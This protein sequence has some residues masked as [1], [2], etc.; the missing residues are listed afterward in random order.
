[1]IERIRKKLII[2]YTT[3]IALILF[4]CFGGSYIA[5]RHS[6]IRFMQDSLHDYLTEE[7]WEAST[8]LRQ[9]K[10][11]PEIH[12]I[13]SDINSSHNFTYW[14][15]NKKL[16]LAEEPLD[17][18]IAAELLQRLTQRDFAAG[19]IYYENIKHNKQKWYFW[20]LKQNLQLEGGKTAEIFVLSNYTPIRKSTKA[21]IK[22][23]V[24]AAVAWIIIAYLV[25]SLLVSRS[26]KYIDMM[27]QKQKQFVSDAS[28]ELRT[29][30]S[31]LLA[32]TELLE[33][34]QQK[35]ETTANMKE[36]IL[37]INKLIDSLLE[38]ARYDS[39]KMPLHKNVFNLENMVAEVV[40]SISLL[41]PEGAIRLIKPRQK[42]NIV[43][44][45]EMLRRLMYILL[46]NAVK[47]TPEQ[48]EIIIR[49]KRDGNETV[50]TVSDNG[51]GIAAGDI[52]HIFERFWRADKSRSKT[53]GLGLGLS[54]AEQIV[55]AHGGKISV[56]SQIGK[57]TDFK[58]IFPDIVKG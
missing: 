53:D 52:G 58:I 28:H 31:I 27:Y 54:L 21:Y 46:D 40:A 34:K 47:Y 50:I 36:E 4:I 41:C 48:K 51:Q 26:M 57:G 44:D 13:A 20:V 17:D 25:G 23:A 45:K 38:I 42:I 56:N 33:Y 16:I 11:Q 3:V 2:K 43:A 15:L 8:F 18:V 30:L 37:R 10:M 22:F 9:G 1:M 32:Y 19:R 49:L 14:F 12:K 24:S 6:H 5:Y 39:C 55:E 29:P 7:L 35:N